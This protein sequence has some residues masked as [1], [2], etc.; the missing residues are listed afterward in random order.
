[1]D[2]SSSPEDTFTNSK[3][4]YLYY[5]TDGFLYAQHRTT[6]D[7]YVLIDAEWEDLEKA[8]EMID[9]LNQNFLNVDSSD[10]FPD[11]F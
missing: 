1:M 8:W 7:M 3:E 4:Y 5:G 6:G 11:D 9:A 2:Y 10:N